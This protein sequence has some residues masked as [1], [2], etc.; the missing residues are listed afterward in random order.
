MAS[1]SK[2][3]NG[4][5]RIEFTDV[6]KKRRA[7]RL[8]KIDMKTT[9]TIKTYIEK[10]VAAQVMNV[11]PDAETAQWVANLPDDPHAKLAKT[12]LITE[13]RKVGTLGGVIPAIIKD[14]SIDAKQATIE[15][16]KQAEAGSPL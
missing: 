11:A 16:W 2:D 14:Q 15:V 6:T 3:K 1:I 5:K 9:A 8:G 7:I 12:G 13:R 10:L 4:T